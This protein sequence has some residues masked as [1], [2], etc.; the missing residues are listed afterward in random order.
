[1]RRTAWLTALL[2]LAA[3]CSAGD[4]AAPDPGTAGDAAPAGDD[5]AQIAA[6]ELTMDRVNRL[7]EA[8]RN[9]ALAVRDMPEGERAA[10]Q[11]LDM[12]D[13]TLAD[14]GARLESIPAVDRALEDAGL[15]GRE[16]A[17]AT[18]AMVSAAMAS[19]VMQMRPN[20]N[21]DSLARAMNANLANVEFFREHEAEL[22]RRQQALEAELR[23]MGALDE[24]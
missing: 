3:A 5:N 23:G 4:D 11:N 20:D 22:T 10:M 16:Y 14:F 7:F 18:M 17:T 1:M 19:S 6:Y 2:A 15:S 9:I 12:N 13:A 24:E 21:H 8:Q